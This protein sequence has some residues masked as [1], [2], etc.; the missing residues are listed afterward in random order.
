MLIWGSKGREI[1]QHSGR[2]YCPQ[3]DAEQEYKL[4]RVATH[5]TL[6]FIPLFETKHHG[7]YVQC[8]RCNG[9]F[10]PDVLTYKPPS[11]VERVLYAIRKDLESGTPIQM[12][13]TKLLNGG[14]EQDIAEKLV[15]VAAGDKLRTCPVCDL[16]FVEGVPGCSGCGAR[17]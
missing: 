13:R 2:F 14:V 10:K 6:Y 9:Q 11:Q 3:C 8:K 17:L 16:I 4:V 15:T 12:A 7:D 5:F 1:E